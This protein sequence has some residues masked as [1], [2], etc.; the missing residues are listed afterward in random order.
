MA[1]PQNLI[2]NSERT[3]SERRANASKAGKQSAINRRKRKAL[4]QK[5]Q[6][7][8]ELPVNDSMS[9]NALSAMGIDEG[10]I[11]NATLMLVKLFMTACEGDVAAVKEIRN[12]IG[13]ERKTSSE[14]AETRA[15]T[16]L[17]NAQ[18]DRVEQ[19]QETSGADEVGVVLMPQIVADDNTPEVVV[20][21]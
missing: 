5:M 16:K 6:M 9:V 19:D 2:P 18:A 7:L 1:N 15:R 20:D 14:I 12:I 8:L 10:E 21:E 13:D 3:P 11:D 17:L 4:K